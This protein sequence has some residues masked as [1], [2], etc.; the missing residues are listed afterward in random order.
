MMLGMLL[1][2]EYVSENIPVPIAA[3]KAISRR[4]P[5]RRLAR[6]PAAMPEVCPRKVD[7][8]LT[9]AYSVLT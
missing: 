2:T 1:A 6:V 5:V 9:T 8:C 3:T 7:T 4:T